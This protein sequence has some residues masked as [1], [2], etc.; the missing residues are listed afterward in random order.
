MR[1]KILPTIFFSLFCLAVP[2][3]QAQNNN[4]FTLVSNNPNSDAIRPSLIL[5]KNG[6][7]IVAWLENVNGVYLV[8]VKRWNG[9]A[10]QP[11]GGMLN[12]DASF[13]SFNVSLAI[14]KDDT[15]YVSWTE[16]S[17]INSGFDGKGKGPGKV[18][19]AR[20]TGS[21]WSAYPSPTKKQNSA[22]DLPS[23]R[24][25]SKGFPVLAWSELTP[26][27]NADSYFVE[28]WDGK[29]WLG[30]DP[31]SLSSDISHASR[32]RELG[33]NSKDEPILAWSVQ[34]YIEGV[35]PQDFNVYI[36][37]WD[38]AHWSPLGETSLN[39][40]KER[41]AAQPSF[42][43]D[44]NDYPVI[45]WLEAT[46]GFD[47]A[48]KRWDGK[49]WI[50]LG[51]TINNATGLASSPRL[52]L[53]SS[54]RPVVAWVENAG[55]LKVMVSRFENNA[56]QKLDSFL[57]IDPKSYAAT[58]SL[59]ISSSGTPVVAWSEEI[60]QTQQRVY[61]RQWNGKDWVGL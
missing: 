58:P 5:E 24:V 14:G 50:Q 4:T 42:D 28:R 8:F 25:D 6:A 21:S 51:S 10:W 59:A 12:R 31:G 55:S 11:L 3:S 18:Y 16:R 43:L 47:V 9:K 2:F 20:W 49:K 60:T 29:K 30:I 33:V 15:P 53:D 22:G 45:T 7:P 57:N 1:L 13:N 61:V 46:L 19:V 36:G 39:L 27:F 41:Y 35:G 52:R 17:N 34:K 48:A 40:N 37:G 32:S 56:W 44:K 23:L 26:D 54:N 38:G